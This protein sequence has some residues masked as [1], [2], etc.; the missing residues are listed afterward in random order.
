MRA[1]F[2]ESV[3]TFFYFLLAGTSM[4]FFTFLLLFCLA[5]T[6][7]AQ[8]SLDLTINGVGLSIGDSEEVTGIRLN[9]RDRAMRRVTGINATIW[10]PYN[11]FGG[12]VHGLALGLPLTGADNLYGVGYGILGVGANKNLE[13]VAF[14]GLGAGAGRDVIG[15][16]VGGLG[17]GAGRDVQGI[18]MGG[19]GAGAGRHFKGIAI[20][21][22][23]VGAGSDAVGLL[24]GG[25]GAGAGRDVKGIVIAGIG[26]GA[27]RDIVGLAIGGIGA[28]A[29]RNF[30][31]ISFSGIATGAGGTLKGLHMAGIA[32]GASTVRGIMLSGLTAGGMDVHALSIAPAYFT[33][34]P[35]GEMRGLSISSFNRIQGEQKGITIGIVNY[36][37]HL[38]GYQIGLINIADNKERFRIMPIF[39]HSR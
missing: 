23:G 6:T 37:R 33:V 9:Y 24:M 13:G 29:G 5:Y 22:L 18:A 12:D 14:G 21:G 7:N 20:G 34:P 38:S 10:T 3:T 4:R 31:G 28:G 32:V 26:A 19:L 36:A 35:G 15:I 1:V 11:N 17:V 16:A 30:T 25:L 27:G 39:N 2:L 8:N